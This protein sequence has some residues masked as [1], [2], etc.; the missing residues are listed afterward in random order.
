MQV[1]RCFQEAQ[2]GRDKGT[3]EEKGEE[4][5]ELVTMYVAVMDNWHLIS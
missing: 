1:G 2:V 3:Q 4:S 5:G